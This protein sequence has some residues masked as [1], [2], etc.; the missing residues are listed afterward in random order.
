VA[1][2]APDWLPT[3]VLTST[4]SRGR[5]EMIEYPL[6]VDLPA[7]VWAANLAALELHVP[8]WTVGPG[9]TRNLP[10]RLVFDL[11][12]GPGTTVVECARVAERLR[13]VLVA[14]RLTPWAK[15]SGSKGMQVYCA[16]HTD[17]AEASSAYAKAVAL[18]LAR[19]TP[20][21]VTATMAKAARSGRVFI[22]CSQN[23]PHK[24]TIAPYSLRGREYPT[25]STPVTWD[26]VRACEQVE[27]LTFTAEDVL[28]RVDE[29]G[30]VFA[31]LTGSGVSLPAP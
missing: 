28:G 13:E 14:D 21:Q 30:D 23:N 5:G 12:P 18:R 16:I 17:T 2:G 11:D 29:L 19:Q 31:G 22:D 6:I 25:V 8:Q 3:A 9:G 10:D 15:T 7:L 26:E 20:D 27:M 24:T 4:G 1:R